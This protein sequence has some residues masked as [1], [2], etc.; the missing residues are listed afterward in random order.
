MGI[1]L[2]GGGG[3][4][5]KK[6]GRSAPVSENLYIRLLVKLY[7]FLARRTDAKFNK[8]ACRTTPR[9]WEVPLLAPL[10]PHA[11]A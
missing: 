8:G 4:K 3:R 2:G 7:R 5:H 11:R 9:P 6:P 10:S 1:D